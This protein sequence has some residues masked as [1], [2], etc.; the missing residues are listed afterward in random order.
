MLEENKYKLKVMRK[1]LRN[2]C[3]QKKVLDKDLEQRV[4]INPCI[5]YVAN[6]QPMNKHI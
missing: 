5:P 1:Y 3:I 4:L 6:K 2:G